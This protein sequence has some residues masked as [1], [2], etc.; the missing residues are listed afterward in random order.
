MAESRFPE[1]EKLKAISDKSQAIGEFVDWLGEAKGLAL[2]E[3][4]EHGRY[5]SSRVSIRALLAEYFDIDE[6]RLEAEKMVMLDE[7]KILYLKNQLRK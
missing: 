4:D 5:F 6:R 3:L 7:M 1:H 2:C